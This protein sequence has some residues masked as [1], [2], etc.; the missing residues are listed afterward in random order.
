M[1]DFSLYFYIRLEGRHNL[2]YSGPCKTVLY[3][4]CSG[5]NLG[6]SDVKSK[7]PLTSAE[8]NGY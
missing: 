1:F 2:V 6:T 8:M 4:N 7:L 5:I 3:V